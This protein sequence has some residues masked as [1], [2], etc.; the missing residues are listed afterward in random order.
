[1]RVA[2]RSRRIVGAR[3]AS[4][5]SRAGLRSEDAAGQRGRAGRRDIQQ[6]VGA[7]RDRSGARHP[8]GTGIRGGSHG[9][10]AQF[11]PRRS[12]ERVAGTG[13][14]PSLCT[15]TFEQNF[16]GVAFHEAEGCPV[17]ATP[18][19]R[20][21]HADYST[22]G[23]CVVFAPPHH[24]AVSSIWRANRT[25]EIVSANYFRR[26]YASSRRRDHDPD[27]FRDESLCESTDCLLTIAF[28]VGHLPGPH[29]KI[30]MVVPPGRRQAG[31][32]AHRH[33]KARRSRCSGSMFWDGDADRRRHER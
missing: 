10:P 4:S 9:G 15:V 17:S 8:P 25:C 19:V 3:R 5:A 1:V 29:L 21:H 12:P 26:K 6:A 23:G 13:I 16:P 22:R 2:R 32:T 11:D 14:S 33:K 28:P 20:G 18:G 7:V 27:C 30:A 31:G 24:R